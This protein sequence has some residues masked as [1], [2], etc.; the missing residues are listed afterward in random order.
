MVDQS[1]SV[2]HK[3]HRMLRNIAIGAVIFYTSVRRCILRPYA[4]FGGGTVGAW[5]TEESDS[6]VAA[7]SSF[8]KLCCLAMAGQ[9]QLLAK[10]SPQNRG[11]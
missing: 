5:L 4:A 11:H 10:K 8:L 1:E 3:F 9:V 6:E 2:N 7:T